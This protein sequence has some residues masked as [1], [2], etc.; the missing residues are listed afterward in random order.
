M[1]CNANTSLW[2]CLIC[3]HIGCGRYS[4]GHAVDH[5]KQTQHCYAVE[6]DS[7]RVWDYVGDNYVHRLVQSKTD[8]KIVEIPAR[9]EVGSSIPVKFILFVRI[10]YFVVSL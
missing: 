6:L 3:G 4:E 9:N 7:Q 8:G 2:M 1:I 10:L 5:W